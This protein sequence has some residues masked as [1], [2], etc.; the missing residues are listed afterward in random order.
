MHARERRHN[1]KRT[2][3]ML[4]GGGALALASP[5]FAYYGY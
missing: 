3:L 4:A 1:M 5:A 2:I